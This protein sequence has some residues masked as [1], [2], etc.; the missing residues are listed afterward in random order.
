MEFDIVRTPDRESGY[1]LRHNDVTAD[2]NSVMSTLLVF[3]DSNRKSY[4]F[5]PSDPIKFL[6]SMDV[7]WKTEIPNVYL[8]PNKAR[9]TKIIDALSEYITSNLEGKS[10]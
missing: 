5:E 2:M 9:V 7:I 6:T 1:S 8:V 10:S 4:W 3:R